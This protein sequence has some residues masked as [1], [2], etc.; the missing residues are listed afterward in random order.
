M[1]AKLGL[2]ALITAA[3]MLAMP[4]TTAQAGFHKGW[5]KRHCVFSWV[6]CGCKR[7]VYTK[8][9]SKKRSMKKAG[10]AKKGMK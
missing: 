5:G 7:K 6:H 4:V 10:K 2:A 3:A 8:K 1:K 9:Y